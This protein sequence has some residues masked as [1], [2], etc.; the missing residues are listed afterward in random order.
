MLQCVAVCCSVCHRM[1]QG[2][3]HS[4]PG[5]LSFSVCRVAVC[6]SVLQCA[7]VCYSVRHRMSKGEDH[8]SPVRERIRAKS[9]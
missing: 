1:S 9:C 7:V 6:C 2:E 4:S 3:D 5:R 8:P